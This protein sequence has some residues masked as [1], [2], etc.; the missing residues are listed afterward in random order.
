MYITTKTSLSHKKLLNPCI[1][2]QNQVK[3]QY[4]Y[5]LRNKWFIIR[6]KSTN[7]IFCKKIN[8]IDLLPKVSDKTIPT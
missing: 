8:K 3:W 2:I 1:Q 6:C 4:F 5:D 7:L